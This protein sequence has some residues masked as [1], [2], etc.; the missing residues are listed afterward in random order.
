MSLLWGLHFAGRLPIEACSSSGAFKYFNIGVG[1]RHDALD[2][3]IA[4][5]ELY[6]KLIELMRG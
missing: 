3:C 4:T 6:E 2:D 1:K 5:V